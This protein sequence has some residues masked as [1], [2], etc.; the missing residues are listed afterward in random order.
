MADVCG[1]L[2]ETARLLRH[3]V[4][5]SN[6]RKMLRF[7]GEK[8]VTE[9]DTKFMQAEAIAIILEGGAMEIMRLRGELAK[10]EGVGASEIVLPHKWTP[11]DYQL[12][13]WRYME[14]GG[15]RAID[16]WH[17]RSGKDE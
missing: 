14:N 10:I 1:A 12:P 4:A 17:R 6:G 15:R 11:R 7:S 13:F 8:E 16:I 9:V 3:L 5:N 2:S